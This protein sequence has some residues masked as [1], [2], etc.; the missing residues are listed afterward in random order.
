MPR[1]DR[2]G[3]AGEGPK[4]GKGM[5]Y[6]TDNEHPGYMNSLP[7]GGGGYGRGFRGGLDYGRGVGFRFRRGSGNNYQGGISDVSEKTLIENEIR[8]LKEQMSALEDRLSN[9]DEK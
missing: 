6:C 8:I 3:P 5:G 4:T 9:N 1:G 2:S 7:R